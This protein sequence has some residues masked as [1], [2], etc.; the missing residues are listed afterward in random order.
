MAEEVG[1][2][3]DVLTEHQTRGPD[4]KPEIRIDYLTNANVAHGIDRA[5]AV[6]GICTCAPTLTKRYIIERISRCVNE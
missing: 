4:I 2:V 6:A 5:C 1:V 3:P